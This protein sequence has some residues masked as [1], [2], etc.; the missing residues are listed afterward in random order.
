MADTTDEELMR[1]RGIYS[2]LN[3]E[4][5]TALAAMQRQMEA[6]RDGLHRAFTLVQRE[7]FA[8][9]AVDELLEATR[10]AID[11]FAVSAA[12][13]EATCRRRAELRPAAWGAR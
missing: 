6:A 12:A 4:R 10:E 9:S 3:A 13:L 2:T 11:G 1:V 8:Y 5:R 7:D